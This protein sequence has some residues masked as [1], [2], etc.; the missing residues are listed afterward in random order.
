LDQ[1]KYRAFISY[2]HRD[3]RWADWLHKS[4]EHYRVPKQL[5]GTSTK[6][7][8]VSK[9]LSP[10][11]R[12]REELPSATDLGALLTEALSK[13]AAQ[14]VICSPNAARSRWVNEEILAF[15]RLDREH[16]IFCLI[17]DGEPNATDLPG[18]EAEEC[19]PPA[20]KFRMGAD[21]NLTTAR[22][23]PIAAD[24]RPG[25]DGKPNAKL[26]IIAG[27]LGVGF[28]A[29]R[30][31]EQ[32]RRNRR[33]VMVASG[34][35][36][37]MVLTT[38]LAAYA[39]VQRSAAQRQ[40]ARAE[41]E[42]RTAKETTKFLVD[43]FKVSD[44]SESRGN[45]I[46]ARE[47]L[48]KGATR[49]ARELV[50]QPAIQATLMDT[51]GTVYTGLG[52]YKDALGLLDRAVATRRTVPGTDPLLLSDSLNHI[53]DVYLDQAKYEDAEKS[54]QQA[55]G[56]E[57]VKPKDAHSRE[58]LATTLHAQGLLLAAEGR[59]PEADKSYRKALELQRRLYGASSPDAARTLKDLAL[60]VADGGDLKAAIPLMRE[61]VAM[62]RTLRGPE[63][64]PDTAEAI[65][66]LAVLLWRNGD[67]DDTE[68]YFTESMA[69]YRRLLGD[70]HIYI[71]YG[72]E[73]LAE[74]LQD[75]GDLQRAEPMYR[76]AL[77]MFRELLG[78][79]HPKVA[80]TLHNLASLQYDRGRV[81]DALETERQAVAA[82]RKVYPEGHKDLAFTL[83][84]LGLWLV[85]AGEYP[86]ADA[87]IHE[88]L[89]MRRRLLGERH[90]DVA[91]S[92][93][94]L[95]HLEVAEHK[96]E[97]AL[98]SARNAAEI[99]T[100]ALSASHWRTAVAESAQ[101]AALAGLGR[102]PE[103]QVMLDRSYAI[104]S[105]NGGAPKFFVTLTQGYIDTL[106][107]E[108]RTAA[109]RKT[110]TAAL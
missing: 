66:D 1:F 48:D 98:D 92:L 20:L 102:Y 42:A 90:P 70:K 93:V 104:L 2:S 26:K 53:G 96:Y 78:D 100:A 105:K 16:R 28:D 3:T 85:L 41:S 8:T 59:Y 61:S 18:R 55:L 75:K 71:A 7:G 40:T 22:T 25:K 84:T 23:E 44:P 57:S 108:V 37:G 87:D 72:L 52:L 109:T 69:M 12:D 54:Y 50:G 95:A 88:A 74:A 17:V 34:A 14:I 21:G 80:L 5:V 9:R 62:Q 10:V 107:R 36:G 43:L 99:Y 47:M 81:A 56:L 31:R 65:N 63:P 38:G 103:A 60:A 46:T 33:L 29:L 13:S 19:F 64:H 11:F 86:E 35:M 89:A 97:P 91:S 76:Q 51:L 110:T 24:A 106:H 67:Y 32:Q 58:A 73:N 83:N 45:T 101:G 39:L 79:A 6:A 4:L 30:R 27:L 49:V 77:D 94:V 68:K 82:Y 15:K